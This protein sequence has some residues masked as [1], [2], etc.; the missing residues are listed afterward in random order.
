VLPVSY[1]GAVCA[2]GFLEMHADIRSAYAEEAANLEAVEKGTGTPLTDVHY[3]PWP[4]S[5]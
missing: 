2:G 1:T 5:R 3:S 4:H